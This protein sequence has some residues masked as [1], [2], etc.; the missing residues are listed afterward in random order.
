[1]AIVLLAGKEQDGGAFPSL[2]LKEDFQ[3]T[4]SLKGS[5]VLDMLRVCRVLMQKEAEQLFCG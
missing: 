2:R 3:E 4:E 1:M 5:L